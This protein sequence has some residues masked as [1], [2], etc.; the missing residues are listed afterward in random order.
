VWSKPPDQ[1]HRNSCRPQ[2]LA[3]HRREF[4]LLTDAKLDLSKLPGLVGLRSQ[5]N[6]SVSANP[7]SKTARL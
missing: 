3:G 2:S 7:V 6:W 4:A 1:R 5:A